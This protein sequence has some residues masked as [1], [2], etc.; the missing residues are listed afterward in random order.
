M[1]PNDQATSETSPLI[2]KA[3]PEISPT[4]ASERIAPNAPRLSEHANGHTNGQASYGTTDDPES[5]S[6]DAKP[7]T[8]IEG[9]PEVR[10]RLPWI[11]PAIAI[12][13][14]L[15]AADQTIIVSSYGKIGSDLHA[16]SST[17]W[18][19]TAYFLT[20]TSFQPLYGKLSDIFGRKPCLLF[21]YLIFGLGCLFCGLARNIGELIAAR[22]FAGIGGGG[23]TTVVSILLS[24][25]VTLRERGTWQGYINIIYAAGAASGAP[26]G[27]I[28]ADAIGWRW[29]F[30][31]QS[32]LCLIA[33]VA[34]AA[35][36]K[37]PVKE[38]SHWKEKL[39]RIDFLGALILICAVFTLL[40]ALDRGSNVSWRDTITLA[41]LGASIPLFAIFI[42]VEMKVATEPFAPG[43]IIFHRSLF[44]C[45]ACNFFSFSGW[46]AAIFYIPLYFQAVDGLSATQ[47]GVR[48]MPSMAF[49]V[50]GSLFA[51]V[52]MQKTGRY[53]WLT[54]LCYFF[55]TV[56]MGVIL[57]TSGAVVSSTVGIIIGMCICAFSNGIGVTS[58]L[59]GLIANAT[60]EDQAIA[61]ACSYLF[62]SLGSVFGVS[63]SATVANQTLRKYLEEELSN[64]E[65][66]REIASKVRE[67]LAFVKTLEPETRAI[68]EECYAKSTRG[69]FGLQ[70]GLVAGAAIAAWFIREKALSR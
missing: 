10:A 22:A 58:T 68:V 19:A 65:A 32:P 67:S 53:Y 25:T 5:Q 37:E 2:P 18:I 50:S 11:L 36:L 34:V 52:Y 3:Q 62:R 54:V 27:G 39:R 64:G 21:A 48:L 47:A 14:F 4:E 26:L 40:L 6:Q 49:G 43:H 23:M 69:A 70:I 61:T 57:L 7:P 60:R 38:S 63:M 28:M 46:L 31:G 8:P 33:F 44:A 17:S 29:A 45:Y 24:D 30:L 55:L 12:G 56:G 13:V 59:I 16:L 41:S 1:A 35:V 9:N 15:S 51:G 20:L 42:L 66:A